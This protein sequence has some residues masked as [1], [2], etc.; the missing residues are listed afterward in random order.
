MS[1]KIIPREVKIHAKDLYMAAK[2]VP[3][4]NMKS[5]IITQD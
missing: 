5:V 4:C 2:I 1:I 3:L